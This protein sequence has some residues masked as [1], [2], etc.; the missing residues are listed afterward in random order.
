MDGRDSDL[1]PSKGSLIKAEFEALSSPDRNQHGDRFGFLNYNL[2]AV[3]FVPFGYP[4]RVLVLRQTLRR[5]D[6][7]ANQNVPFFEQLVLDYLNG[8]RSFDRN[9]FQGDGALS[10]SAEYRYP[11]WT[12]W[13]AFVFVDVGQSFDE[14]S[15]IEGSNFR[16]SEGLGVR[17][18]SQEKFLFNFVIAFGR[19]GNRS[20]ISLGQV[21]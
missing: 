4:H 16:W 10:F 3:E 13:D 11:I 6:S 19:D 12:T 21:F 9:R 8:L 2:D 15:S 18:M 7:F 5:V 20:S 1:R 17:F 14:F